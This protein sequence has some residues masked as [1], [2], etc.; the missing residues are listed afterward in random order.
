M[1]VNTD[2]I[3]LVVRR[4]NSYRLLLIIEAG[5]W[6]GGDAAWLLQEKLN[7]AASYALDG[8]MHRMYPDSIG[9]PVAIVIRPVDPPPP[10]IAKFID[11][12]ATILAKDGL[13]VTVE[14]LPAAE[15]A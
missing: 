12:V 4:G 14:P 15:A 13:T 9:A 3:E 6:Q 10:D 2:K 1:L 11:Q 8:Q 5:E 7:A